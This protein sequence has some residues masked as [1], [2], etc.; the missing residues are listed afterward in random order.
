MFVV[1]PVREISKTFCSA[2]SSASS[3]SISS[4]KPIF[5]MSA[6]T[7][8]SERCTALSRTIFAWYSTF[9][10]VVTAS[11]S[12]VMKEYGMDALLDYWEQ[13]TRQ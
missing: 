7:V 13:R 10:V 2:V 9:A 6:P 11:V 8:I 1:L 4:L 5:D 12:E 3:T